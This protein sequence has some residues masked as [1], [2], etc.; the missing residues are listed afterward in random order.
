M[1]SERNG[2]G[3]SSLVRSCSVA[4]PYHNAVVITVMTVGKIVDEVEHTHEGKVDDVLCL[5]VSV[6]VCVCL[7]L[8]FLDFLTSRL[9]LY[10]SGY[11][12]FVPPLC[13]CERYA[14]DTLC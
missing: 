1:A 6:C 2:P 14:D 11:R 4:C 7:L 8:L 5:C 3:R 12:S 13:V 9:E 10:I